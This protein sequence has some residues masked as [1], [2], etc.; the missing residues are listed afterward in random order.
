MVNRGCF[1]GRFINVLLRAVF[2]CDFFYLE[3]KNRG[4]FKQEGVGFLDTFYCMKIEVG[5]SPA[6]VALI[7]RVLISQLIKDYVL[8]IGGS[9][10]V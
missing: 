7:V 4:R 3:A 1:E 2:T 6:V 9:N 5:C 8:V 10:P